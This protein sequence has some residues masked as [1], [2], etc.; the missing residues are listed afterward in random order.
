MLRVDPFFVSDETKIVQERLNGACS[1]SEYGLLVHILNVSIR[2]ERCGYY[3]GFFGRSSD[4]NARERCLAPEIEGARD[5]V[6]ACP[7]YSPNLENRCSYPH[8]Q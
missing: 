1:A 3:G 6:A 8:N 2:N 7:F 5:D 4:E